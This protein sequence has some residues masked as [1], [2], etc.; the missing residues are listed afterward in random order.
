MAEHLGA[1]HGARVQMQDF[2]ESNGRAACKMM[3]TRGSDGGDVDWGE[4]GKARQF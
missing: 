2:P 3:R 1:D 4:R